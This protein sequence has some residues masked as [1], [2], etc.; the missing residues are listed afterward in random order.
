MYYSHSYET[1]FYLQN[2]VNRN[3]I[4]VALVD[5]NVGG[6]TKAVRQ[7]PYLNLFCDPYGVSV[8]FPYNAEL[9][10]CVSHTGRYLSDLGAWRAI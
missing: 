5:A 2:E 7:V 10:P 4:S 9:H 6:V 3:A 8:Q 1:N